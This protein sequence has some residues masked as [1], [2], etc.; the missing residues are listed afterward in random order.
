METGFGLFHV[1][2]SI[3]WIFLFAAWIWVMVSVVADVFRS[4]DL[5]GLN[6]ALWIGLSS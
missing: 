2:W 3:V 5:S 1:F 6:K 4:R